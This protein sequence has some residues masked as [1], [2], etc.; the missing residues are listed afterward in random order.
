MRFPLIISV[1]V[2]VLLFVSGC[3][4]IRLANG[5]YETSIDGR[6]DFAA[7][8]N[9][10]IIIRLRNPENESG[11]ENGYWEWGGFY[12]VSKDNLIEFDM[13]RQQNR[14]WRFYYELRK[15]GNAIKVIDH[16]AGNSFILN[17]ESVNPANRSD[18]QSYPLYK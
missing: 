15:S 6:Q 10:M 11:T 3:E 18:Q 13:D 5:K 16:R 4:V 7:V 12:K 14:D 1:A 9:D 2:F 8:Y 17:Y